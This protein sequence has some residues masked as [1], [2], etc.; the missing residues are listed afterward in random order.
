M[1]ALIDAKA[2]AVIGACL[3]LLGGILGSVIGM[4]VACPAGVATLSEE[5]SQFRNVIVLAAMP[6]TQTFYGLVSTIIL[7]TSAIPKVAA[8]GGGAGWWVIGVGV[9]VALSELFSAW[10]QGVIDAAAIS[11]LPKT[12]G[13]IFVSGFMLALYEELPGTL[14][15]VW[16]IIL[17]ALLGLM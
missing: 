14:G 6:I 15:I 11:L 12:K 16:T 5:P 7:L 17:S 3:P 9:I 1:S 13:Q 10:F 4:M 2:L 8:I